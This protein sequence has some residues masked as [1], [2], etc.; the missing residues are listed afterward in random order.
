MRRRAW[1]LLGLN[2]LVPGSA[3]LLAGDRRWG[4]FAVAST[5]VL[6]GVALGGVLLFVLWRPAA[7]TLATNAIVLTVAQLAL[8]FYAALW[9]V[10]TLDALRLV[11]LVRTPRAARL[12]IALFAVLSIVLSAGTA[13]YAAVLAGS[14]RDALGSVFGG[15]GIVA[16]SMG[17]TPFCCSAATPAPTA[18]ACGPTASRW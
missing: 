17:A 15:G 18:S 8:I 11:R 1:W 2:L 3:Q 13:G 14:G 10:T 16:P 9:L 5:F 12:P 6:W 4:R 7:L